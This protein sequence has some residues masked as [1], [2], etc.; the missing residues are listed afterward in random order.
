MSQQHRSRLI[1]RRPPRT[2]WKVSSTLE[3]W[4]WTTWR[5]LTVEGDAPAFFIFWTELPASYNTGA[6]RQH[7]SMLE[8][9]RFLQLLHAV[10]GNDMCLLWPLATV[11]TRNEQWV[12]SM[13]GMLLQRSKTA[14]F[15][16]LSF[17]FI[18]AISKVRQGQDRSPHVPS[19]TTPSRTRRATYELLL[20]LHAQ[21]HAS[22][23]KPWI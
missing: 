5:L 6:L 9:W 22:A 18:C 20:S 16:N 14:G 3:R 19:R 7:D 4:S 8:L 2:M 17:G 10:Q 23:R 15:Q 1:F 12:N 21:H 13:H 11:A